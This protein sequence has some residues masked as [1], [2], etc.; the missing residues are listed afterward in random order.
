MKGIIRP[1]FFSLYTY[2]VFE[3]FFLLFTNKKK[4]EGGNFLST[5]RK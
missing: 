2:I 4:I 1:V 3:F 5:C